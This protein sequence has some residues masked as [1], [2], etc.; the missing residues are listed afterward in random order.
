VTRRR[1]AALVCVVLGTLAAVL[2][3]GRVDGDHGGTETRMY[4]VGFQ[5]PSARALDRHSREIE[6]EIEDGTCFPGS[7]HED[8][9]NRFDHAE[10]EVRL[11]AFVVTAWMREEA[12][13]DPHGVCAGVGLPAFRTRISLPVALGRRGVVSTH[14]PSGWDMV[15][16]APRGRRAIR[17]LVPPFIYLDDHGACDSVARYFHD[18]PKEEWCYF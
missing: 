12:G 2:A 10:V 7:S 5:V 6:I 13:L 17:S 1:G 8:P 16:V 9:A 4:P 15:V 3:V 18:K 14:G 11:S